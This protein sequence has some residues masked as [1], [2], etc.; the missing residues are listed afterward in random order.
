[1]TSLKLLIL[2][3][4]YKDLPFSNTF[5]LA[6]ESGFLEKVDEVCQY[7]QLVDEEAQ[8][9]FQLQQ[10]IPLRL[11]PA[12]PSELE[13]YLLTPGGVNAEQA[14]TSAVF[15]FVSPHNSVV[16]ESE[17]TIGLP[18]DDEINAEI[19]ELLFKG[20]STFPISTFVPDRP[21]ETQFPNFPFGRPPKIA[22]NADEY[23]PDDHK[24]ETETETNTVTSQEEKSVPRKA[25]TKITVK[26]KKSVPAT[27]KVPAKKKATTRKMPASE[28]EE[29]EEALVVP[30]PRKLPKKVTG[31]VTKSV[32]EP[33]KKM[34]AS[35]KEEVRKVPKKLAKTPAMPSLNAGKKKAMTKKWSS[36]SSSE[37]E[38]DIAVPEVRKLPKKVP[39][40]K[41]P[42]MS[43]Y[44]A[45]TTKTA[46]KKATTKKCSS[47]SMSSSISSSS[48]S[49]SS[50]EEVRKVPKKVLKA[51]LAKSTSSL[52]QPVKLASVFG[53]F[54]EEP[55]KARKATKPE[56]LDKVF[57]AP[58]LVLVGQDVE[59]RK[60]IASFD[61][62]STLIKTLSGASALLIFKNYF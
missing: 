16:V 12:R 48:M 30:A 62:D 8:I 47:S 10:Y 61:M 22:A 28:S 52:R 29:E 53:N 38:E 1:M 60:K 9:L 40:A 41:T 33:R 24:K 6:C 13:Q 18:F 5:R 2:F 21:T 26:I 25:P 56:K 31:K 36:M 49:S 46:K 17:S 4:E 7:G 32:A 23:F 3:G 19:V 50:E 55:C 37:E 11:E 42:A 35:R 54:D 43:S 15:G 58:T 34:V 27:I 39:L 20:Q 57:L 45:S 14:L 51:P 59:P 44:K